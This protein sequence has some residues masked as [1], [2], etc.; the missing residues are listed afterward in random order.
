MD[1]SRRRF[2]SA[3]IVRDALKERENRQWLVV[4]L[5]VVLAFMVT[6]QLA[7]R[8]LRAASTSRAPAPQAAQPIPTASEQASPV[9]TSTSAATEA[10]PALSEPRLP[11]PS[12]PGM[13]L[14]TVLEEDFTNNQRRWPN[15]PLATAWITDGVYHLYARQPGQFVAIGAP[16]TDSLRDIVVTATFRKAGGPLGGG[17]GVIVRDQGPGPRDG[18]NQGGR[19]YVLAAGDRGEVGIWR[20]EEDH[21]VDLV[22]WT[23]SGAVRGCGATN[24]LT[25]RVL[26]SRLTLLVNGVE[27]A[28]VLD[29][30]LREGAVGVFVGGD[31]NE[32]LLE[33]L[34]VQI[35]G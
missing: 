24:Q 29:E 26:G 32:V 34:L 17:Y 10:A 27:V 25:A 23:P 12:T 1:E 35:P 7:L 3:R 16:L 21:W 33:R 15:N 20:R 2:R 8:E 4:L 13:A 18:V 28:S 22:P 30:T 6:T 14:H 11:A 19:Y 9:P 5:L 31:L